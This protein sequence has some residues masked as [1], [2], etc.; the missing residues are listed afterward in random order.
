MLSFL[1]GS[2]VDHPMAD[3]KK[4]KEI[5][6]DENAVVSEAAVPSTT[7]DITGSLPN[8]IWVVNGAPA[9]ILNATVN[10]C[11]LPAANGLAGAFAMTMPSFPAA[12]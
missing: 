1:T 8:V 4:A 5:V 9:A 12:A 2:K 11:L 3:A 7:S 10:T 6:A